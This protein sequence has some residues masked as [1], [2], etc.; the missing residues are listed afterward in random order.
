MRLH[1]RGWWLSLFAVL[2]AVIVVFA[3][4]V[5]SGTI[6]DSTDVQVYRDGLVHVSQTLTLDSNAPQAQATLLCSKIENLLVLDQ[7]MLAMDYKVDGENLL[8]YSFGASKAR[9]EYDTNTLTSKANEIWTLQV[10]NPYDFK[11]VF[12]T[13]SSV[14]YLSSA[15][16]SIETINSQVS[17]SLPSGEWEISYL[18]ALV[19]EQQTYPTP[20]I[21]D[22][23]SLPFEYILVIVVCVSV[24]AA[25]S[26][27]LFFVKRK[28]RFNLKKALNENPQL[29]KD[30]QQVLQ[31]L[32]EKGGSAF[33][34]EIRQ[35]FSDMPRT[36]LW[37]LV[38]RLE[39]LEMVEVKKIGLENQVKLKK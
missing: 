35:Q 13:N 29:M 23:A 15:P 2:F 21:Q 25:L 28:P 31:F 33:E 3:A 37:R 6:I 39:K 4:T 1:S 38:K 19:S 26:F 8:I 30:D 11:V 24:A 36:S 14:I 16:S 27:A 18:L 7:N 32:A 22:S 10:E 34:A 20:T 12:P 5:Q 17:L 9:I